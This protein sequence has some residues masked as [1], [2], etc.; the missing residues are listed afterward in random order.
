VKLPVLKQEK[1]AKKRRAYMHA[2]CALSYTFE[3]LKASLAKLR[4]HSGNMCMQYSWQKNE[5]P[6]M[7]NEASH[8][9]KAQGQTGSFCK[10]SCTLLLPKL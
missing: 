9:E 5:H 2:V 4:S 3:G 6:D 7:R 10:P 8:V 1:Q